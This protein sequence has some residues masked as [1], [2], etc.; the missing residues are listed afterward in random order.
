MQETTVH[1]ESPSDQ[2]GPNGM[3]LYV[4]S[5]KSRAVLAAFHEYLLQDNLLAVQSVRRKIN[6]GEL[7]LRFMEDRGRKL[8]ER[9]LLVQ[10]SIFS[11]WLKLKLKYT[12]GRL[13][14]AVSG[15]SSLV[16]FLLDETRVKTN[17]AAEENGKEAKEFVAL[18]K[19]SFRDK[20]IIKRTL[21]Y[22]TYLPPKELAKIQFDSLFDAIA[23]HLLSHYSSGRIK[24]RTYLAYENDL[25]VFLHFAAESNLWMPATAFG[26]KEYNLFTTW[27][28]NENLSENCRSRYGTTVRKF[29]L[30]KSDYYRELLE[31][32][33]PK[34]ANPNPDPI[35]VKQCEK[36]KIGLAMD[37]TY[38]GLRDRAFFL[39]VNTLGLRIGE[40]ASITRDSFREDNG[41]PCVLIKKEHT[42]NDRPLQVPVPQPT[43]EVFEQ[44]F[45]ANKAITDLPNLFLS[46]KEKAPRPASEKVLRYAFKARARK[47][48]I[49]YKRWTLPHN[50]RSRFIY[51]C[52]AHGLSLEVI[53]KLVNHMGTSTLKYYKDISV[54]EVLDVL[55]K[56]HPSFSEI[57]ENDPKKVLLPYHPVKASPSEP[58]PRSDNS[59][60]NG[61]PAKAAG[62]GPV[63][64][65]TRLVQREG[66]AF[67]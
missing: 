52:F 46:V 55:K 39:A 15:A 50:Q 58:D 10:I 66:S 6:G 54:S 36:L 24:W 30:S 18:R 20:T 14:E 9:E 47:S 35:D 62:K 56:Y 57:P 26:A 22:D 19:W 65:K 23:D 28:R 40:T 53:A 48:G 5:L 34:R 3:A 44:L 43:L 60:S 51:D 63:Q 11:D 49:T 12:K 4:P 2:I 16:H 37:T 13:R 31:V 32:R 7:F 27:M 61:D 17:G 1:L 64:R 42:K 29:L 21:R 25:R 59:P 38:L 33:A 8:D 45:S 41:W 67:L